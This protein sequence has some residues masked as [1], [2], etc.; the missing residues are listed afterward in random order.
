[1]SLG[2]AGYGDGTSLSERE[3]QILQLLAEAFTQSRSQNESAYTLTSK[4]AARGIVPLLEDRD[5]ALAEL[6]EALAEHLPRRDQGPEAVEE[7]L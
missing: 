2:V 6:C 1:M 4:V 3:R 5:D 7:E